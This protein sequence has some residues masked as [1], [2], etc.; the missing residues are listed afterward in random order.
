MSTSSL[1]SRKNLQ[2]GVEVVSTYDMIESRKS[3]RD[4]PENHRIELPHSEISEGRADLAT[5]RDLNAGT[6][7]RRLAGAPSSYCLSAARRRA[8]LFR[9]EL[10]PPTPRR[11]GLAQPPSERP[12]TA[13]NERRLAA[14]VAITAD[15]HLRSKDL[16]SVA[17]LQDM[18]S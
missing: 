14:Y 6:P 5:L 15:L 10:L 12:R 8:S 1:F 9:A 11:V 18:R 16:F 4:N 7:E 3:C 17:I 13:P 2:N